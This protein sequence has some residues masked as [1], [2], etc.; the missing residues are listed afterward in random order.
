M[1]AYETGRRPADLS[2]ARKHRPS[3]G[4]ATGPRSDVADPSRP[5][6]SV[7]DDVHRRPAP[8][9]G[10]YRPGCSPLTAVPVLAGAFR[11]TELAAG[12]ATADNARFFDLPVPVVLHIVGASVYC[13]LGAFQFAPG[14]RRR[15]PGWHRAAG[16]ILVPR[17]L[18]AALSGMWMAVFYPCRRTTAPCCWSSG[19]CFG[20]AMVASIVLGLRRGPAAGRPAAPRLDDPR[21]RDRPGRGHPGGAVQ[22]LARRSRPPARAGRALLMGAGVGAQSRRRRM[23]HRGGHDE[24]DRPGPVRLTRGPRVPRGCRPGSRPPARY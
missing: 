20:A 13:V 21:L 5:A 3:A 14:F 16:R 8:G 6:R 17:G 19:S 11:V 22:S 15:R 2:T 23:D 18:A 4:S 24:S 7:H 12:E 10:S 9:G 1:W